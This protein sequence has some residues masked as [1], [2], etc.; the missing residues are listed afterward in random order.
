MKKKSPEDLE[1]QHLPHDPKESRKE[2]KRARVTDRSQQKRSDRD[3]L[4]K[5]QQQATPAPTTCALGRILSVTA[6]GYEVD[7]EGEIYLCILRRTHLQ[8][9]RQ[10]K[11]LLTVGDLVF[12]SPTTSG[13]G[14]IEGIKDRYSILMRSDS[15]Q[16]RHQHFIAANIDQVL[17]T[18][19]MGLP[20]LKPSLIDRYIIAAKKG[21]MGS[22]IVIN[23]VDLAPANELESIAELYTAL[24]YPVICV[25]ATTGRGLDDLR[26][27]MRNKASVFAGQSGVGKSSLINAVTGLDLAVG[28]PVAKTGKGSHTTTRSRLIQL[29]SGGWC[30]DTPGIK[31]FGLW[32]LSQ[33]EVAGFFHEIEELRSSCHYPNCSHTHE[34]D[35]AV[36]AAVEEGR[37]SPL[38][39]ESYI[40]L[41]EEA[42][43]GGHR[44]R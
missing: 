13:E 43:G 34:P 41:L 20:S 22:V 8:A 1:E 40:T 38:R 11:G 16:A 19:S 36:I 25:S 42:A 2:R 9:R 28:A 18:A 5:R 37:I 21:N 4:A 23:K 32:E 3:Q 17:I 14:V 35:C 6:Q 7:A 26:G 10:A 12:F 15:L 31:S 33:S 30:I 24:G 27:V 39:Y 44:R 29:P